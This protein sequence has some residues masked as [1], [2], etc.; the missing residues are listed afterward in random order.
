MGLIFSPTNQTNNVIYDNTSG[1]LI[2]QNLNVTASPSGTKFL[3]NPGG[4]MNITG[5][6]TY[7]NG[8]YTGTT[9]SSYTLNYST[10]PTAISIGTSGD[11]HINGDWDYE[12]NG[13]MYNSN[14]VF[15]SHKPFYTNLDS[16][17]TFDGNLVLRNGSMGSGTNGLVGLSLNPNG[18]GP[19]PSGKAILENKGVITLA[20]S[21]ANW[22]GNK[23]LDSFFKF[24]F[25]KFYRA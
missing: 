21:N 4:Q 20:N 10:W 3:L 12:V 13:Y 2:Y 22:N 7:A 16:K 6:T 24:V 1:N 19:T 15:L 8:A 11:Y 9:P 23:N 14:Y 18:L 5:E 25:Q 17:V